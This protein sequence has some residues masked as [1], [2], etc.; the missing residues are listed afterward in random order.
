MTYLTR[1]LKKLKP[2]SFRGTPNGLSIFMPFRSSL[3]EG[4][5]RKFLTENYKK[6]K[7]AVDSA[8][9]EFLISLPKS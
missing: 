9:D 6:R 8:W 1:L 7:F 3:G 2:F 5:I 4:D